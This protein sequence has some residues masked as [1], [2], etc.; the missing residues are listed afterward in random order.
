MKKSAYQLFD[1]LL[2]PCFV[3]NKDLK[4]VYCNETASIVCGLTVRKIQRMS[5]PDLF[6]FSEPLEWM[7]ALEQVTDATPYK[8]VHFKTSE[9]GEGKVQI[10]CQEISMAAP[11]SPDT[12]VPTER[13]WI[14]FVRDVT[15]EERL[16]KKYR[17][18][19]EQKEGYILELQKAQA[20]LE[21]YSKNLEKMVEERTA[22]IRKLNQLMK[23]L[24]DSLSQGF[25]VFDSQGLC[26]DFS[27]KACED[28]LEARP[29]GRPVWEVLRLPE[30]QVEGFK[31][32]SMTLFAEMLP[33]EDLAPLGPPSF[34]H[35]AGK[36]VQLQYFPLLSEAGSIEG[37]I[38]VSS[39]ITSLVEAQRQAEIDREHAKLIL[40]L[41]NKKKE[42]SRFVRE[43]QT[44]V[45]ELS[46]DLVKDFTSWDPEAIFR[47]LHT[48]KGGC[49]SF[50]VLG[51]AK[52]A[53]EAENRL[54]AFKE[55][56][57]AESARA[58]VE[59]SRLVMDEFADFIRNTETILGASAFSEERFIEVPVS[60]IRRW[61][62]EIPPG[63]RGSALA[64]DLRAKYILEPVGGFFRPYNEV[65]KAVAEKEGKLIEDLRLENADLPVLPEAYSGLFATFVHAF[66]N[67]ADHGIESPERR[68]ER[69]KPEQGRVCAAFER[70]G[71]RLLIQ[72]HDDGGGIDPAR[73]RAKL[74]SQ[75]RPHQGESDEQVIQHIFDSSFSTKET[76]TETSGRG[77]GMDAI[78]IAAE[79]LGGRC[80]VESRVGEGSRLFVEVPWLD[81]VPGA[82][83]AA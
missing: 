79:S 66:R 38:V 37:V 44:V 43:T 12:E 10:C 56:P 65:M 14:V 32:W 39:D 7:S 53:H 83:K 9:G 4:V 62:R 15:L 48:V 78:R 8:E 42:I 68:R 61:C 57:N 69:G 6:T 77:V 18:E 45:K 46:G 76:V 70:R 51:A 63:G 1:A 23:A 81:D 29:N 36:H 27:S 82:V 30:K 71:D 17:G 26:L 52:A 75:G 60:E 54:S 72:I 33:F 24:F 19:L 31:K 20:E 80:W 49:A 55:S 5:F 47:G 64:S 50:N 28:L 41:I 2:E 25:F 16:Q 11:G 35:S 3:V 13:H 74:E 34:P 67:A 73:I 40:N 21:K 59:Q 58:L 22:E